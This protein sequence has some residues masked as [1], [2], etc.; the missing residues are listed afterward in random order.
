MPNAKK[1]SIYRADID[2]E[3]QNV[4]FVPKKD[5]ELS[6]A[7]EPK[8]HESRIIPVPPETVQLLADLQGEAQLGSPYIFVSMQRLKHLLESKERN[9]LK[10]DADLVNNVLR[11]LKTR[12]RHAGIKEFSI[13]DLRRSCITNWAKRL[14]IQTV[15]YLAGHSS[16]ET[17]RKYYLSVQQDDLDLARQLQ[18]ASSVSFFS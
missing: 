13:H 12:C 18:S 15:Q 2:F 9:T 10:P 8:D 6:L 5:S 16:I 7:W 11:K 14:P 17:T 4:K 1:K 3:S